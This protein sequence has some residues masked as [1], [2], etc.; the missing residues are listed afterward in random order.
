MSNFRPLKERLDKCCSRSTCQ[1]TANTQEVEE[2][3]LE[4]VLDD[5]DVKKWIRA[6]AEAAK[7]GNLSEARCDYMDQLPGF[8]WRE[9]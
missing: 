2:D 9:L 6:Q 3:C 4:K 7:N 1:D 5:V 8:N